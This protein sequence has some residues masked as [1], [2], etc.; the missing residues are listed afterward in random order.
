MKDVL[1]RQLLAFKEKFGRDPGPSDPIFFDPD[2]D[3]PHPI[4]PGKVHREVRDLMARAGIHPEIIYAT[5]KTGRIVTCEKIKHL[6]PE[7]VAEWEAAV[8]EYHRIT[9]AKH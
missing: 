2:A 7:E 5:E 9:Q 4:D 1:A 6:T 8:D 3:A